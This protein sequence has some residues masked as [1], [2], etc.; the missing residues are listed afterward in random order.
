VSVSPPSFG[1][2]DPEQVD[3][4]AKA[5]ATEALRAAFARLSPQGS[6]PWNFMGAFTQLADRFGPDHPGASAMAEQLQAPARAASRL[7]RLRRAGGSGANEG[8]SDTDLD[9]AM[10]IVVEAFRFLSARVRT[11]EEQLGRLDTPLRGPAWIAPAAELGS[12]SD[13]VAPVIVGSRP[14]GDVLHA[15]CGDGGLLSTLQAAG[16]STI[17]IE[18]RGRIALGPLERGLRVRICEVAEVLPGIATGTLGALVLSGVVDRLPVHEVTPL[19]AQARRALSAGA[20]IVIIA[21]EPELVG[22]TWSPVRADLV[23]GRPLHE[24]TWATLLAN[25][26]FE[27][28]S[29]LQAPGG[30]SG[31]IGIQS[32]VP[33]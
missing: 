29:V 19:L 31:R 15:D 5:N 24:V 11:L 2:D 10:A 28:S 8:G 32:A 23:S 27:A 22:N 9:E 33:R 18:P 21:S 16:I 6:D 20:L 26:G 14:N 30:E 25:A 12:W 3:E 13:V 7:S 4:A 1:D 17:G